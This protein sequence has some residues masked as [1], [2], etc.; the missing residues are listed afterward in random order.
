MK[1][2]ARLIPESLVSRVYALY[3]VTWLAFIC[4]GLGL[5]Y[6]SQFEQNIDD[7]QQAAS[8][9]IEVMS[10]TI[11]ESAVIGDYDSIQRTLDKSIPHSSFSAALFI[12]LTGGKVT[13]TNQD[14]QKTYSP[15]W[16]QTR[17]A[18]QLY[19]VNRNISVGGKDYGVLRL[20][21]DSDQVAA[22]LW[23]VI[24]LSLILAIGSMFGGMLMIWYPL[25]RWLGNLQR[26]AQLDANGKVGA[27]LPIDQDMIAN[28]PLE[29]RQ[30]L[31]TLQSTAA[32]L[33]TELDGREQAL[34]ALHKIVSEL[35]PASEAQPDDDE[36][37]EQ[38]ISTIA[39]LVAEREQ[40]ARQMQAAK[41][42]ADAANQAKSD[43]LANMSHEIR[44][45]MNGII[46]M[47]ELALDTTLNAEQLDYLST[48]RGSADSLLTIINDILDFSK[49]EAG[50]IS[51]ESIPL[52]LHALLGETLKP[53]QPI[54]AEKKLQLRLEMA[55][56]LP[57]WIT[58][59]PVRVRQ[60]ITNL[61][62]NALKFTEHGSI[63]VRAEVH[64]PADHAPSLRI[65]IQDTGIGIPADK[66]QHIFDAFSQEDESTTRRFGGTGLGLSICSRLAALMG[67]RIE[68]D[69][70][71]GQGSCFRLVLPLQACGKSNFPPQA[72]NAAINGSDT[73]PMKVL[74]AED[75]LVNQKL[76]VA[77]LEA[78]G[79]QVTLAR[80]GLEAI[81]YWGGKR[82]DI[83]LMDM[84]MP[85][86]G[87]IEAT[88]LIREGERA[89]ALPATHIYALTAAAMA[90]EQ[91]QGLEAGLD[92]YLT[93]PISRAALADALAGVARQLSPQH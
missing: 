3:S 92:G 70:S 43:F 85:Q 48:A 45:P 36:G 11:S 80:N 44:T 13:S 12:D 86:M 16:L 14:K 78:L 84:H 67:G 87:G 72:E 5:F 25:K 91:Q 42:A 1:L 93:K 8:M 37:I 74:V 21:F 83:I 76:I 75:N 23:R 40:S 69:S 46:G 88:R 57:Q 20:N 82:F 29:F 39:T 77:L 65:G 54:A 28:A 50:K 62:S 33:R 4:L 81:E 9:M 35:L 30:T 7:S 38:V 52:P 24:R 18:E 90:D 51:I 49:I 79:H 55:D 47:I 26:G 34:T 41:E 61:L 53:A 63:T 15:A 73:P 71:P 17:V 59:D 68:L 89:N 32:Q 27:L 31:L 22:G 64:T 19:E 58:G 66:Q 56:D 6:K 10:Q 60:I 2:I